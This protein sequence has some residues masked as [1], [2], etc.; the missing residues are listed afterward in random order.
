MLY[1]SVLGFLT[2]TDFLQVGKRMF[3][4]IS[5]QFVLLISFGLILILST[6]LK[7]ELLVCLLNE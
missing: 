4:V 5:A 6:E 1:F 3:S 2:V 7:L